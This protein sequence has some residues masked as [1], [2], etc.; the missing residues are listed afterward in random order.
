MDLPV[1]YTA[2]ARMA[3]KIHPPSEQRIAEARGAGLAP[4]PAI[5]GFVAAFVALAACA[6][7]GGESLWRLLAEL[8]RRPLEALAAG[9]A[10]RA[11]ALA[12]ALL[13]Q[14]GWRLVI[15]LLCVWGCAALVLWLAQGPHFA[16]PGRARRPFEPAARGYLAP[17]LAS[18]AACAL[19]AASLSPAL[20]LEPAGVA[21]LL[22]RF[23]AYLALLL[24]LAAV[25]DVASARTAF[26]RALWMTRQ[27]FKDDNREAYGS[28]ELRGAR[29][30]LRREEL[31][32]S[33]QRSPAEAR[34]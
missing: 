17:L 22:S 4:R 33:A 3:A 6:R 9:D 18:L 31:R 15:A 10:A 32:L 12:R 19:F 5:A 7:L 34:P 27:E 14:I 1:Y 11:H 16:L 13:A 28:P 24:A 26:L 2:H 29:A 25:I 23:G 21:A 30:R 8:W 20:W